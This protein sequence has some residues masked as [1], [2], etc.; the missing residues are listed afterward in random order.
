MAALIG[1]K[2]MRSGGGRVKGHAFENEIAKLLAEW[3]N[4]PWKRV[5]MSGGWS[6]KNIASGDIFCTAEFDK[7]SPKIVPISIEIKKVQSWEFV[8]FFK[9]TDSSPIGSWWAQSTKD[10]IKAKK[11]PIVIFTKNYFPIF[12]I[13]RVAT[14]NKLDELVAERGIWKEFTRI[15]CTV[16]GEFLIVIKLEDFLAWINFDTLLK[17]T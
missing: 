10:A 6:A 12:I 1:G 5:P 2:D 17:L 13:L 4:I 7:K 14:L 16:A 3:S 9:D 15:N 11:T 8:H